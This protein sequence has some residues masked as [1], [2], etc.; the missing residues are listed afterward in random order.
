MVL[1]DRYCLLKECVLN[2]WLSAVGKVGG[3]CTCLFIRYGV[4]TL[5]DGEQLTASDPLSGG[6]PHVRAP[7]SEQRHNQPNLK[8]FLTINV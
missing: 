2:R 5:L 7:S 4:L 8:V 3:N 1:M 6:G